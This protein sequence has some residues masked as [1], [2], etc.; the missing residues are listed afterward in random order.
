MERRFVAAP[1][2]IDYTHA[3]R[4]PVVNSLIRF[5]NDDKF[6]LVK[7]SGEM[8]LFPNH[9][10]G[11]SGFLDDAQ[12]VEEKVRS[13]IEEETRLTGSDIRSI[14]LAKEF[15]LDDR[16]NDKVWEVHPAFVIVESETIKLN[17]EGQEYVWV[18]F[19]QLQTYTLVPGF[20]KVIGAC[21]DLFS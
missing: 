16:P 18:P 7:R 4:A 5:Q 1:G 9:W 21:I 19:S 13:E 3:K 15:E 10:N 11:I 12:S 14:T 6:L 2:Q 17:W 20:T 8:R